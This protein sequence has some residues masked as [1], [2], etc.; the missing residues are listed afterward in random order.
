MCDSGVGLGEGGGIFPLGDELGDG[1]FDEGNVFFVGHAEPGGC[2]GDDLEVD[3]GGGDEVV[4]GGG[5]EALGF[6]VGAV[7]GEEVEE[8]GFESGKDVGPESPA[9]HGGAGGAV[10]GGF[11]LAVLAVED[12]VADA[13]DFEHFFDGGEEAV[14]AEAADATGDGAVIGEGG[15]EAVANHGVEGPRGGG[16]SVFEEGGELGEGVA[17]VEVI[18]VDGAE[19]AGDGVASA[20]DGMGGAPGFGAVVGRAVGR[21][22]V[23]EGLES[24]G[25]VDFS[26]EALAD[27]LFEFWFEV[28]ADEEDDAVKSGADGIEDGVIEEGF[29]G[30]ADGFHLF[31]ATES[32]AHAGGHN[33]E[34]D[35]G[36]HGGRM[37]TG[38]A[39]EGK[40]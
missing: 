31:E 19:G 5:D 39:P 30:G 6:E 38:W 24:V 29:A 15:V 36:R 10:D 9:V 3:G 28:F 13:F 7:G 2:G 22:K 17:A 1:G 33:K 34:G 18:G 23:V 26:V 12:A 4:D 16:G 20:P 27:T 35:G 11:G 37:E 21:G 14:G 40:E 25:D 8:A 32:A